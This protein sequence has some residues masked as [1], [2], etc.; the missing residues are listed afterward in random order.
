MNL[1]NEN[2]ELK[3]KLK[4]LMEAMKFSKNDFENELNKIKYKSDEQIKK[5]ME[6]DKQLTEKKK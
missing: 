4:D 6:M 2:L 1:K 5:I 3:E